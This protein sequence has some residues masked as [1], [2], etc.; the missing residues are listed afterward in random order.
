MRQSSCAEAAAAGLSGQR[1]SHSS[2]PS[3][4]PPPAPPSVADLLGTT[5]Q[6]GHLQT[7]TFFQR[8]SGEMLGVNYQDTLPFLRFFYIIAVQ[9][10]ILFWHT[11][12]IFFLLLTISTKLSLR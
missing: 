10:E 4:A 12:L 1:V 2:P 7:P 11:E 3:P 6:L 8:Q 9:L 5:D